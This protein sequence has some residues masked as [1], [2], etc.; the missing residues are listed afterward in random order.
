MYRVPKYQL[1]VLGS[2]YASHSKS[3]PVTMRCHETLQARNRHRQFSAL[4]AQSGEK[5]LHQNN[6]TTP[7]HFSSLCNFGAMIQVSQQMSRR[8]TNVAALL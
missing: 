4:R 3:L 8:I 6:G 5:W 7:A 1:G 2:S